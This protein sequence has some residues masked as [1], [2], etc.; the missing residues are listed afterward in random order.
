[1]PSG[2]IPARQSPS[3]RRRERRYEVALQGELRYEG[4]SFAVQIAD[5]SG[6]GALVFIENPPDAGNEAELWIAD[7]GIVPIEIVH[8]GEDFCGVAIVNPAQHRDR[9]LKWLREEV[10]TDSPSAERR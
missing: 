3:D 4:D 5:V 1:M 9:L 10:A 2:S 7:Y 6:S 8:A